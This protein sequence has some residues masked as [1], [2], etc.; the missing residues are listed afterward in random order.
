MVLFISVVVL[1]VVSLCLHEYAH[2]RVAYAG[3]DH[4]VVEKGYLTMNPLRYMHP[5]MSVILPLIILIIGGVPLP[6]GAVYIDHTRLRSRH[7]DAAVSAAGPAANFLLFLACAAIFQFGLVD[8]TD[9]TDPLAL[10]IALFGIFQAL[11]TFL[12]LLPVPGLDG[13]GIIAPYLPYEI[14]RAA[15]EMANVGIFLLL[16]L[17]ITNNPLKRAFFDFVWGVGEQF[18]IPGTTVWEAFRMFLSTF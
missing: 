8:P 17:M 9:V 18:G 4:S 3:G 7:W 1:W 11:A 15:Y 16:I 6:G 10:T 14:R 13:F 2:A 5:F 12:N